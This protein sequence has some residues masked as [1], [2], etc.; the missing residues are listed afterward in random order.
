[1]DGLAKLIA[2]ART[3]LIVVDV[4]NDYC[5][6]KGSLARAGADVSSADPAV[7]NIEKLIAAARRVGAAVIFVR[8]WHES[9]TDSE[10]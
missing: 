8:N 10:A 9:W 2:P 7:T 4:Q 3:A 1:M 6:P 5:D